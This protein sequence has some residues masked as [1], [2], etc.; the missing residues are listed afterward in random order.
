V[1]RINRRAAESQESKAK[2]A[3]VLRNASFHD[4]IK[5]KLFR[6]GRLFQQGIKAKEM[7]KK[8]QGILEMDKTKR[9]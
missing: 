9:R 5:Q 6:I 7:E 1:Q 3:C 8:Q 2:R 4:K